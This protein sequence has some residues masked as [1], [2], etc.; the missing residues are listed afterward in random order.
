MQELR[1]KISFH[2]IIVGPT[3]CGK[4]QYLV[5]KLR[6]PFKS[7]FDFT[8][9]ICPTYVYNKTYHGFAKGDKRFIIATPKA[10]SEDEIN[11]MLDHSSTLFAGTNT[12]IILDN[13]A[14]SKEM[15]KRS[16]KLTEL[17]FSGRP[18]GLSVWV[19]TQQ[20]TS[21]GKPFRDNV[22]CVVAFYISN[23]TGMQIL[24]EEYGCCLDEKTRKTFVKILKEETLPFT[25][26]SIHMLR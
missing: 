9:L 11:Q 6:G 21:I 13:C 8:F 7:V 1:D 12:L 5:E 22:A 4:T 14:M 24:F 25:K 2:C 3:N 17:A 18:K 20:L 10:D 26:I 19:L 16:N 15:K 23:K